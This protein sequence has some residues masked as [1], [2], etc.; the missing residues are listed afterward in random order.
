[1]LERLALPNRKAANRQLQGDFQLHVGSH[2]LEEPSV[3]SDQARGYFQRSQGAIGAPYHVG[4][5]QSTPSQ[6]SHC[7]L[8]QNRH[9]FRHLMNVS[10]FSTARGSVPQRYRLAAAR[11]V[12]QATGGV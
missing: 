8:E 12:L 10:T 3:G 1:M 6:H 11:C 9:I 4:S 2:C 5:P 7:Y